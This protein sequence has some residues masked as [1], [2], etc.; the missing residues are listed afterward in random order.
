MLTG[1][2]RLMQSSCEREKKEKICRS[3]GG[4]S[5]AFDGAMIVL[6]PIADTAHIVHGPISCCGN[7]WEGRG[8]LSSKGRLHRMGFTTDMTEM[9]IIYGSENKLYDA[10]LRAYESVRP[11]AIFV[12]ATCV[13]GLIGEDIEAVCKKAETF[14]GIRVI[15]VNAPGFVGP[16]NL[17][18]R[19]AGEVLLDYVIGTGEPPFTTDYDINLIG[20]YNIAGDLWLVEP[21]LKEAG[22]R[23]LSKITGDS[24]FEEITYAHRA[25]LNVVVC[26]RALINIARE[27]ERRYGIPYIEVSFFGKTEMLQALRL[28]ALNFKSQISNLKL[29]DKIEEIIMREEKKLDEKLKAYKHLKGKKAVLYTGGVKSWSFISALM[30]LGIEIVAIG[31]K[32]STFEDEEKMKEILGE[33]APLVEDVTPKNLLRL[34]KERNADILIAGGRNQYLA[35][36][37][38]FPFVD[39]N[40]ERHI[41]YAG[42]DGL[43]N[44]AEQISNSMRFF[45]ESG[46]RSQKTE[47]RK[48]ESLK[49][50]NHKSEITINPLKHSQSIGAAI[51]FQGIDRALPIIHGAQGC[52]FLAKVLLTKHFRE[53]I[54]LAST[55]L[56]TE[57][58]VMGSEE[59][60]IKVVQE[61]VERNNPDVIGILTSGL[62]EVK[63]DD[64]TSAMK[65]LRFKI[66]DSKCQIV[67]IS[68]PD[69]EGGL[70]TGYAKAVEAVI[71]FI[72]HSPQSAVN[73]K[74]IDCF[75][76]VL[77]GSHLTPADFTELRE[78]VESFGLKPI[79]L[80]D[81]SALDGSRK[82][83]SALAIGGTTTEEI[84]A[85]GSSDFTIAIGASMESAAMILKE[86]FGIE[87]RVFESI[88]GL[89]DADM[90]ME[91]L[92][93]LSGKPIAK[94][95]E[96]QRRILIDG[97]RD[98]HFYY[99]NKKIYV[100]L[101]PDL[102]VQTMHW[103]DEMGAVVE[104]VDVN[105]ND[106]FS[107]Q[108]HFDLLISNSHAEDT[109]KRLGVPLYQMGFPVYKVLGNNH[110]VTIGYSGTLSLI[111][112]VANKLLEVHQ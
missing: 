50:I 96:R 30:D 80:P 18:N 78:I 76:N 82:G 34:I 23:I 47:I 103:L 52:S 9:D 67:H 99:G 86:R 40:Q 32:K 71:K 33:D 69:Y 11:K 54:A 13:S 17:G 110:K 24:T 97:M 26:S 8:T 88:S 90:F 42:Y 12:H 57:D 85:M 3:R 100:A 21:L 92:S 94:K 51:A 63:G 101:E 75:I 37:E 44:F 28:I 10:I 53:P 20:E 68:T 93:M 70:E 87:Y 81:L 102:T 29:A 4:E 45:Q 27:M 104:I 64:V 107:I 111:N 7:S 5:C 6:Q 61:I 35:I 108:G 84:R 89:K 59:N 31:T 95:Y 106:L 112:E 15:P 105:S 25:K 41:P 98:A 19:I 36:K 66:K 77:V 22:V 46:D 58:V 43:I 109:A 2:D 74:T 91:T 1:I 49:I 73:K 62:T 56:F 48:K 55:K 72:V 38:G 60:I 16:K 65:D 79:I 39:V 83:F 14:L